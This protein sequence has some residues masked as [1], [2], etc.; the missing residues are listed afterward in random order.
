[1]A[2]KFEE[3]EDLEYEDLSLGFRFYAD[4]LSR[5]FFLL[6]TIILLGAFL[7]TFAQAWNNISKTNL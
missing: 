4:M 3:N 1:M 7:A 2:A 5:L 6:V